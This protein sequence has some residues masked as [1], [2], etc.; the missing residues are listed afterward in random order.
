MKR[1]VTAT[2]LVIGTAWRVNRRGL[3]LSSFESIGNLLDMLQPLF[4]ALI[5]DGL[6]EGS[7]P[8]TAIGATGMA[9]SIGLNMALQVVG[10]NARLTLIEQVGHALDAD[11]AEAAVSL[12]SVEGLEGVE[13]HNDLQILKDQQGTLGG[14]FSSVIGTF[15]ALVM[16]IGTILLAAAIAPRLL[17]LMLFSLPAVLTVGRTQ[18]WDA[19]AEQASAGA[20]RLANHLLEQITSLPAGA[21]SRALGSR[22]RLRDH[23][24]VATGS[25]RSP[26]ARAELRTALVDLATTFLYFTMA[27]LIIGWLVRDA[28]AG[29]VAAGTVAMSLLVAQRLQETTSTIRWAFRRLSTTVRSV[30]RYQRI[31][32]Q[33]DRERVRLANR[34]HVGLPVRLRRG[35]RLDGLRFRYPGAERDALQCLDLE[36]P[37]GAIVAVVGDNGA[38][39]T[40]LVKL[41]TKMYEPTG[42]RILV[43]DVDLAAVDPTLWRRS[44]SG[45]FQEHL[46]LE[47][48]FRHSVGVGDL[49]HLDDTDYV[50]A[51]LDRSGSHD[52]VGALPDGAD[53]QL[54]G[55]WPNGIDL[56]GGQ[57]Q[58]VAVSRAMLRPEPLLLVLDEPSSALDPT[59]Q[60]QLF[61][62]YAE[63]RR[64]GG[65]TV[66]VT[67][68]FSITAMADL[69]VVLDGGRITEVGTH[70]SLMAGGGRY[71]DLFA[72]QAEHYRIS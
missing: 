68:R 44:S 15:N 8:Q 50:L 23:L 4:L 37:E 58:R 38:G 19:E 61:Q 51:A 26:I 69:I 3:V 48:I 60:H 41:L 46:N 9:L 70:D 71:S 24:V 47:L 11:I 1:L 45:T 66:L 49:D 39:K 35:V 72:L 12:P 2:I 16:P 36:I 20:G 65:V 7:G 5:V 52:L 28:L 42:G 67:H 62:R 34:E 31:M 32:A 6:V 27:A 30:G 17:I 40:T 14:A 13:L 53:T 63:R 64:P 54:G 43:D 56:S 10:I 29:E 57:W 25:W 21:E 55:N 18:R 59:T 33:A 22:S